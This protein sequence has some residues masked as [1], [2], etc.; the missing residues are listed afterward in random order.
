MMVDSL[1]HAHEE[2][3]RK[4]AEQH[5]HLLQEMQ[6]LL[7]GKEPVDISINDGNEE[8]SRQEDHAPVFQPEHPEGIVSGN[9]EISGNV[10]HNFQNNSTAEIPHSRPS[11][12]NFPKFNGEDP[13][14][15]VWPKR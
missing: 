7:K 5:Q 2:L 3:A 6:F 1:R 15:S 11:C 10:T 8:S 9:G 4:Q 14:D 13:E 12:L